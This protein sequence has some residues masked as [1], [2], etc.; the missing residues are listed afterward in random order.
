MVE[1]ELYVR[2]LQQRGRSLNIAVFFKAFYAKILKQPEIKKSKKSI[3]TF[4]LS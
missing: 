4:K 2:F 3:L 1:F